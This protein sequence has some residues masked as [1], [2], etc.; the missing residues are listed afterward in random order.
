MS[1]T[2]VVTLTIN[3]LSESKPADVTAKCALLI[4]MTWE[5]SANDLAWHFNI[6]NEVEISV[7]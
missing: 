3:L 1:L 4:K 7:T 2:P 6:K 5:I